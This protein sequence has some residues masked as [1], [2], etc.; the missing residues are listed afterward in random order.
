MAV[1]VV[2]VLCVCLCC[3]TRAPEAPLAGDGELVLELGRGHKPLADS[4]RARG[5]ELL[6]PCDYQTQDP[7]AA[8]AAGAAATPRDEKPDAEAPRAGAPQPDAPGAEVPPPAAAPVPPAPAQ[9]WFEVELEPRQ[10]LSVLAR[11]H[12]GSANRF[13]EILELN[14]WTDADARRLRPGQKVRI[15]KTRS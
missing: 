4:L 5:V 7:R 12:L 3:C 9:A 6:P 10:T 11:K 15:P 1:R 14:G 8:L 2:A 13:K